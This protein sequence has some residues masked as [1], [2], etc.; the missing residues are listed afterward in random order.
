M[1]PPRKLQFHNII[2]KH[3][4]DRYIHLNSSV[5]SLFS[6]SFTYSDFD[7][8]QKR[9][10]NSIDYVATAAVSGTTVILR[11]PI[12]DTTNLTN[13]GTTCRKTVFKPPAIPNNVVTM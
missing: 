1:E 4:T 6:F 13:L 9:F 5:Q 11:L 3:L 7:L 8:S 2:A 12:Q 10:L